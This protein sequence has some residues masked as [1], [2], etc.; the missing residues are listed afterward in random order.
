MRLI[1]LDGATERC[2]AALRVEGEVLSREA[3]SA[4]GQAQRL[5]EMVH[6]LLAEAGC[7]LAQLDGLAAT[8]GPGAFTGVRVT[9]AVAQGLALGAD[10]PVIAVS[11]LAALA[12]QRLRTGAGPVLACLDARMAE[13]YWGCFASEPRVGVTALGTAMVSPWMELPAQANIGTGIGRGFAAY[14]GLA[15]QCAVRVAQGDEMALPHACEVAW[16]GEL[17]FAAGLGGDAATLQ[18][19]YLRD[20]IAATEAERAAVGKAAAK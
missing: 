5:I 3:P 16:L 10:L 14:P 20:K 8:C 13:V 6:S 18:P 7:T 15:Q 12:A 19:V 17:G 9:V 2:S 4:P 1:A 11:S